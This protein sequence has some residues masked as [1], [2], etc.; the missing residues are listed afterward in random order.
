MLLRR[1]EDREVE[2]LGKQ[3]GL[4]KLRLDFGWV[5]Q[6]PKPAGDEGEPEA[7]EVAEPEWRC[8]MLD[9]QVCTGFLPE[10]IPSRSKI[11]SHGSAT[12]STPYICLAVH[13]LPT[14]HR[15]NGLRVRALC[16]MHCIC[17]NGHSPIFH[18]IS[19]RDLDASARC[20]LARCH[21]KSS[22]HLVAASCCKSRV[23]TYAWTFHHANIYWHAC[24][25]AHVW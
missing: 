11:Q 25:D 10:A 7:A 6:P 8:S 3:K 14:E 12:E 4:K 1:N 5:M 15:C 9:A 2:A 22:L 20:G 21:H 18:Q 24:C 13:V 17:C 19:A 23:C 16:Q